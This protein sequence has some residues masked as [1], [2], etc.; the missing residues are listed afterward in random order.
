MRNAFFAAIIAVAVTVFGSPAYAQRCDIPREARDIWRCENGFV[1]GPENVIIRLPIPETDPEAL[2]NA[3]IEAAQRE[4][5][6]IAIAYFTAAQQRAHL[7]PRY[8][9]N[10][11]LAHA[12][13]GNDVAAIAWFSAYL[14]TEPNTSNRA[15]IWDQ[16]ATLEARTNQE[17]E[18][19][20][21]GAVQAADTL[22]T[23]ALL[24][25]SPDS[26]R[27]GAYF[28][29]A[30]AAGR[31]LNWDR[32]N[33]FI[34]REFDLRSATPGAYSTSS[35][36]IVQR[37]RAV[38][39]SARNAAI[40]IYDLA[41]T[42]SLNR[43]LQSE[44]SEEPERSRW[45]TLRHARPRLEWN[46]PSSVARGEVLAS[47]DVANR[48]ANQFFND[49]TKPTHLAAQG[50]SEGALSVL[51]SGPAP[52]AFLGEPSRGL[53][54]L[55]VGEIL[56][57]RGDVA[58]A[59]RALA[60]ARRF[61]NDA[62]RHSTNVDRISALLAAERGD[63]DSAVLLLTASAWR[64]NSEGVYSADGNRCC[65]ELGATLSPQHQWSEFRH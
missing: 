12:R 52:S 21:T 51:V 25:G 30:V 32:A 13:A 11:G 5:W 54:A 53:E 39:G 61:I 65:L 26:A 57:L 43:E 47:V 14:V 50:D 33:D 56:L 15:A 28:T 60:V 45:A 37:G 46:W 31:S 9:Y 40:L 3:G 18:A 58:G 29:L 4:D 8:M 55:H 48:N 17:M 6:R 44:P 35:D 19:L 63:L 41:T 22:P 38:R 2:Y 16:I 20:W 64:L 24:P 59:T 27:S 1:I 42:E 49:R 34:Q 7:V 10:L 23:I 36:D 62:S